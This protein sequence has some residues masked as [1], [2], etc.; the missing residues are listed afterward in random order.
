MP[1][2]ATAIHRGAQF[3]D[4]LTPHAG[5]E[6]EPFRVEWRDR[7][8]GRGCD[9]PFG[10]QGGARQHV[11]TATGPAHR[12]AAARTHVV[13]YGA[14]IGRDVRHRATRQTRGARVA[15]S[16]VADVAKTVVRDLAHEPF[17]RDARSGRAVMEQED[18][19][20]RWRG[21]VDVKHPSIGQVDL[22]GV[23]DAHDNL[24]LDLAP[25]DIPSRQGW[26]VPTSEKR[27][28]QSAS[29][30]GRLRGNERA[31]RHLRLY[32]SHRCRAGQVV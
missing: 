14:R 5:Q 2:E 22:F 13:E 17:P 11:G 23:H 27:A 8:D 28:L 20:R 24:S 29:R 7:C 9:D 10:Q 30:G 12:V 32:V 4:V 21:Q 15:G 3:L 6:I 31:P 16:R 18:V 25:G 26:P 1:T 19:A